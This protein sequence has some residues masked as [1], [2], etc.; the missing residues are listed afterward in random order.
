MHFFKNIDTWET[1]IILAHHGNISKTAE[2]LGVDPAIV[3]K[4]ISNLEKEL[5]FSLFNRST[6]PFCL[7]KDGEALLPHATRMINEFDAVK[8]YCQNSSGNEE[9]LIRLMVPASFSFLINKMMFDYVKQAEHARIQ[10]RAPVNTNDFLQGKADIIAVTGQIDLKDCTLLPRGKMIFVPVASPKFIKRYGA[11]NNPDD[12]IG[13]PI[14]RII[15]GDINSCT[16]YENLIKGDE[17]RP[18]AGTA[19]VEWSNNNFLYQAVLNGEC[20]SVGL[21]LFYCI[22]SLE[23]GELVP[24]L[25]GW[26][27]PS[28]FNYLACHSYKW[29]NPAI[30]VFMNWFAHKLTEHEALCEKRFI[31]LF[32]EELMNHLRT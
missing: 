4:R 12:L 15:E 5:K 7:T 20:A 8:R 6:R 3:S 10:I 16:P 19:S 23:K 18:F 1:F 29:R 30:R 9:F 2:S 14:A 11:V 28:Q 13:L 31:S 22:D 17:K 25:N 27:R 24:I 21:P 32:G 26:H